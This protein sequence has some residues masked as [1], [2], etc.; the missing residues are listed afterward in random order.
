MA[1]TIDHRQQVLYISGIAKPH[2]VAGRPSIVIEYAPDQKLFVIRPVI[3]VVDEL[4]QGLYPFTLEVDRSG[5]E[6]GQVQ[7]GE[8]P[9]FTLG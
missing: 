1:Q 2:L 3:L 4:S 7:P 6:E 9:R 8:E 5:V